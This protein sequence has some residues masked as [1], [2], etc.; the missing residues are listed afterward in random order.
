MMI[1]EQWEVFGT[2]EDILGN[3]DHKESK[4]WIWSLWLFDQSS[5][6]KM[7]TKVSWRQWVFN[8]LLTK[9]PLGTKSNKERMVSCKTLH[10]KLLTLDRFLGKAKS[11]WKPFSV[12]NSWEKKYNRL[13]RNI[14]LIAMFSKHE[15]LSITTVDIL[16]IAL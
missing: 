13:S 10:L 1:I 3:S 5:G 7:K 6:H 8:V 15:S 2:D 12:E 4:E 14:S 11:I 16:Y 9:V